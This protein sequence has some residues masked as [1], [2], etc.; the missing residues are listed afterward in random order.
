MTSLYDFLKEKA[1]EQLNK[2][3]S[4]VESGEWL[5]LLLDELKNQV[6]SASLEDSLATASLDTIKLL[7]ENKHVLAGLGSHAFGLLMVQCCAG[8]EA[9]A[10]ETYIRALTNADDLIALMNSGSDGVI[11]AKM[12]LDQ[13]NAEAK[14]L[15]INLLTL[16][17]R[18]LLP[19]ILTLI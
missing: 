6:S 3:T 11:K 10:I 16:G 13:L 9:E 19:F 5:D 15:V 7:E 8:K 14:Q 1:A 4:K 2:A 18:T 12:E 17:A